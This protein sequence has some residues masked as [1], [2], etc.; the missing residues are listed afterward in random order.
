VR[1]TTTWATVL[2]CLA[3][4]L[5]SS[6]V[7]ACATRNATP[8]KWVSVFCGSVATWEHVVKAR[9]AKLEKK[10]AA[11]QKNLPAARSAL[12]VFL[13]DVVDSSRVMRGN[14][15]AVGAPN[16]KNG[17]KIQT[18]VLSAFAQLTKAFEDARASARQ[19]PVT[20]QAVFSKSA[21]ALAVKIQAA[22]NRVTGAFHAL[23]KYSA[24]TLDKVA[25]K[26]AACQNLG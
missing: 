20:S 23:D 8:K 24:K 15:K 10:T 25:K 16:V 12:V 13:G 2:S 9:E 19:L 4:V 21:T 5:V 17:A 14:V 7:A 1:T 22:S 26:T 3:L 18:L 11:L 6:G